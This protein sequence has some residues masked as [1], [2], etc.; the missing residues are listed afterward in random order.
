MLEKIKKKSFLKII[1]VGSGNAFNAALGFLF[2]GAAA[3]MLPLE[4]FGKYALLSALLI[5]LAKIM[6]FGTN[7]IFVAKSITEDDTKLKNHFVSLKLILFIVSFIVSLLALHFLD[8]LTFKIILVFTA[9]LIFYGINFTLFGFYQKVENYTMLIFLNTVPALVKGTYA[10]LIFLGFLKLDFVQFFQIFSLA[11]G[12]SA[13]LFA[14]LPKEFKNIN[15]DFSFVKQYLKQ[16]FSPGVSQLIS[17]GIPAVN[18]SLAKIFT[19]FGSVGIYSLADKISS[20][21]ALVSFTIFTVLLPQN[22]SRK[23]G[24]EGY[25]YLETVLLSIGVLILAFFTIIFSKY[26]IP[27]VFGA[28]FDQSLDLLNILVLA[29]AI[30]AI[31]V[32][33]ENY[34]YVENKTKYLAYIS[35]GKLVMLILFSIVLIPI[36]SLKGLAWAQLLAATITLGVVATMISEKKPT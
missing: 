21:F 36:F 8:L 34:F 22:A 19:N 2:L 25:D 29:N 35:S 31:H 9:G 28:K 20:A 3:K 7:S 17:E 30:G 15:L 33:L 12:P 4:Q 32:F 10:I 27:L 6:D 16:A 11:I 13:L 24:K 1:Y 5:S 26:L 23:K 14:F 18:N